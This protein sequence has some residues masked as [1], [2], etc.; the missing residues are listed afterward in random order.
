[1]KS[2]LSFEL[3]YHFLEAVEMHPLMDCPPMWTIHPYYQSIHKQLCQFVLT[4][5]D[6]SLFGFDYGFCPRW[7]VRRGQIGLIRGVR[8]EGLHGAVK[9]I[10]DYDTCSLIV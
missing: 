9:G 6:C 8:H 10:L 1:M 7:I 4:L 3:C 2:E 5:A